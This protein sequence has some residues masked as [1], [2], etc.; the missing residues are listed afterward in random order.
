[1]KTKGFAKLFLGGVLIL[2]WS[3]CAMGPNYE[4]PTVETPADWRWKEAKPRDAQAKGPWWEMFSDPVLDSLQKKAIAANQNLKAAVAR[5]D[6]ARARARVSAADFYPTLAANPSWTRYRTTGNAASQG[7]FP[8]SSVTANDFSL[9]LDLSYEVDLWGKV[10]RG[11]EAERNEM[12]ATAADYQNI[13]FTLQA[14]VAQNYYQLRAIDHEIDILEQTVK[15]RQ[16]NVG[17]F[18]ARFKA[19]YS[20]DLDLTRIQTQLATAKA[21]LAAAKQSRAQNEN[22]LAVLCGQPA[23]T[24]AVESALVS[25]T[26][27]A[28][29][30][31][32]PSELLERR[33]DVAEAERRMAARNAEIGVAYTAF[34][35]SLRLT[36]SG[37]VQSAELKDLFEWESRVWT[38]G[39]SISLPI[40]QGGR[41]LANLKGSRAA[42]EESVAQY[43]QS[44]LV[45]FQEVDNALAGLRFLDEQASAQNDAVLSARR[46]AELSMTRFRNG[47]VDYLDVIDA[48]RSRLANELQMVRVN[49][50]RMTTTVLLVKA[51]GGGWAVEPPVKERKITQTP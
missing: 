26:P 49:G 39:P 7:G 42:Y 10:R 21:D 8:V 5:V 34:F 28:V 14:D 22:T 13:L 3:G 19:G 18:E 44:I 6:Q 11:F 27:P 36:A 37:G 41:N 38:F 31:G 33:P 16:E 43:R 4:R 40:F 25:L 51:I 46:S 35:P 24:F 23:A 45:A 30:P 32:L 50:Q 12:L 1:M 17:I 48:E 2:V 15:L 20:S 9:P 47:M 29:A